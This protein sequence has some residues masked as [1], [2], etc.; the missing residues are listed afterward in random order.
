MTRE[1]SKEHFEQTGLHFSSSIQVL[2]KAW[3]STLDLAHYAQD[4][5]GKWQSPWYRNDYPH[6]VDFDDVVKGIRKT[7]NGDFRF[8]PLGRIAWNT[9][10]EINNDG[11]PAHDTEFIIPWTEHIHH[12][13][14]NGE[15]RKQLAVERLQ[16]AY[17]ELGKL[18]LS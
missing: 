2:T 12:N 11:L 8:M 1:L 15:Q 10:A 18:A 6:S 13:F 17:T 7:E 9:L 5:R 4:V 16:E 3:K 14:R